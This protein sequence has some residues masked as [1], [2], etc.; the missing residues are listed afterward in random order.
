MATTREMAASPMAGPETRPAAKDKNRSHLDL[1]TLGGL[2]LAMAGIIGG[3]LLEK[4]G[5]L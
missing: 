5:I 1:A 2:G 4:G 3:L